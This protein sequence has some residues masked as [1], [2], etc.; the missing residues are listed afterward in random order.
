MALNRTALESAIKAAFDAESDVE[1]NPAEAR[2]RIAAKIANA[3]D[4]FVRSGT[5]TGTCATPS[6]A[7]TI[8]GTVQ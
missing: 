1:V 7:G 6:G 8:N 5:V 4:A 2:Q 3:I